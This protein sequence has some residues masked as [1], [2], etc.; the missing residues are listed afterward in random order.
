M[1]TAAYKIRRALEESF[2]LALRLVPPAVTRLLI[3]WTR[4]SEG[5]VGSAC[6]NAC[7]YTLCK[8]AGKGLSVGPAVFIH[9]PE[10]LSLGRG[11]TFN[12]FSV[13]SAAGG[14]TLGD[15]VAIGNNV[16]ILTSN[17]VIDDPSRT[18][19][20]SGLT[21]ASTQIGSD[22]WIGAGAVILAGCKLGDGV[23]VAAQAVVTRNVEPYV[24]V[25]GVPAR[26]I[27]PRHRGGKN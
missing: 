23:V 15:D 17:H 1:G 20:Q 2:R 9:S 21:F 4:Y 25:A 10:L 18:V 13:V 19:R 27:R 11:V 24:V 14:L 6:R 26:V 5:T 16:S 12:P 22:V 7:Y 8:D 3:R